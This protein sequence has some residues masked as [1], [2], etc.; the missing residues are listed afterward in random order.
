MYMMFSGL[1]FSESPLFNQSE[2]KHPYLLRYLQLGRLPN[3]RGDKACHLIFR[4][5][6]NQKVKL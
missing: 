5:T 4:V 6:K 2:E 1:L 3:E